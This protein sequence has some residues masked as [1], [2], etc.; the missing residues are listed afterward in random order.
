MVDAAEDEDSGMAPGP[1]TKILTAEAYLKVAP[2]V[3]AVA[4]DIYQAVPISGTWAGFPG[5]FLDME[6]A[7]N[8]SVAGPPPVPVSVPDQKEPVRC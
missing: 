5:S 7:V 2:T 3:V 1:R 6:V 8:V 4:R